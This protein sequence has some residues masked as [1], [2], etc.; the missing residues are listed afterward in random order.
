MLERVGNMLEMKCHAICVTTNGFVSSN[1]KAVMGRGIAKQIAE[2]LPDIPYQLGNLIARNGNKTQIIH[3]TNNLSFISF[4]V[5]PSQVI[6]D[7]NNIVSHAKS[8]YSVGQIVPGFHAVAEPEIIR[9][10]CIELVQLANDNPDWEIILIPRAGCG[11]GELK[12]EDVKPIMQE[13]LD[14]RFIVCT[15]PVTL[16]KK[17]NSTYWGKDQAKANVSNKFIGKG[18][19]GSSTELYRKAYAEINAAN[20]GEYHKDIVFVSVNGGNKAIDIEFYRNELQLAKDG[21]C[22]IITDNTFH[23][24]REYNTGERLIAELLKE[25]EF[26]W[27]Q[28]TEYFGIWK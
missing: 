8:K 10:S 26:Q 14:D 25:L 15:F 20:I 7:S 19:P 23:R 12:W 2:L 28:D 6:Y 5:K 11:A 27:Q 1:G 21:E 22:I 16:P 3:Q 18:N 17:T 4:P 24:N 13:Y 9:R